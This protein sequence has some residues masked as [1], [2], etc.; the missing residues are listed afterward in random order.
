MQPAERIKQKLAAGELVTGVLATNHV[1]PGLI[2]LCQSADVDYLIVDQEHGPYHD[3]ISAEICRLG[4]LADFATL[5]RT[6]STDYDV[7]RR[8]M[9]MGPC[10]LMFPCV[11]GTQA[12]DEARDAIWMPPRGRRRPGGLG[13][14]WVSNIQLSAWQEQVEGSLLVLPQV[15]SK[16]GLAN[17]VDIANHEIVTSLAIGPYDLSGSLGCLGNLDH[18]DFA[19]ALAQL[20]SAAS[21]AGKPMWMIGDGQRWVQ[22]GFHFICF[23]EPT[24]LLGKSLAASVKQMKQL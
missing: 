6:I 13:N 2:E 8:A 16:S 7:V 9:D 21:Q 24:Q 12:L 5:I 10:G 20:R 22:E 14:A 15:E 11:D 4:R 23:C 3:G 19:S 1:W 17:A 18:P